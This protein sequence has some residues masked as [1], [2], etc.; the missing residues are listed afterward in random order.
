MAALKAS[1][2]ARGQQVPVEVVPLGDMEEGRFGLISGL[3]RVMALREIGAGEVLALI[4]RPETS[5]EAYL[6]MVE[7]NEIRAGVSFYERARVASEAARLGLFE[8]AH[9]AIAHLFAQAS[10]AKR[11]KI[12]SFV[13]VHE[14]LGGAL[15]FPAAIPE[16]LGLEMAK[17]LSEGPD[18]AKRLN[19]RLADARRESA[20][21]ERAVIEGV[22]RSKMTAVPKPEPAEIVPGVFVERGRARLTLSGPAVTADLE[23]GLLAWLK[24][25]AR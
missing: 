11:S 3:R 17:A 20:A 14:A 9:A 7:E 21:E 19:R 13:T 15:R 18:F 8:S 22:L 6:A 5:A 10:P 24:T 12:G 25:Q 1:L 2:Q 4:R 23:Q 16:R